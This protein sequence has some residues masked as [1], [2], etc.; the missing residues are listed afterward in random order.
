MALGLSA[1]TR[2]KEKRIGGFKFDEKLA[3]CS[4]LKLFR[5]EKNEKKNH[6]NEDDCLQ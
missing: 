2:E 1:M 3:S 5:E 6:W 4:R